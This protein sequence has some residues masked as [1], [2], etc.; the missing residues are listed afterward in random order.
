MA[1]IELMEQEKFDAYI[2][3][4]SKEKQERLIKQREELLNQTKQDENPEGGNED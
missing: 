3:S 2:A 4:F 1:H